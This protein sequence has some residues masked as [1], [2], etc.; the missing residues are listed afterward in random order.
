MLV[1]NKL[2][3][4]LVYLHPSPHISLDFQ[5]FSLLV[6]PEMSHRSSYPKYEIYIKSRKAVSFKEK[7]ILALKNS[8]H[9]EMDPIHSISDILKHALERHEK[10]SIFKAHLTTVE[11]KLKGHIKR[12]FR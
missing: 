12:Q 3:N 10:I 6:S 7:Y 2:F 11:A 1:S 4:N 5:L 9:L 8:L